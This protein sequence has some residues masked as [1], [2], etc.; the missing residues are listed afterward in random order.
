MPGCGPAENRKPDKNINRIWGK[1]KDP[2][3]EKLISLIS[4]ACNC[5][6]LLFFKTTC[7]T[8]LLTKWSMVRGSVST[9]IRWG[10]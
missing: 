2:G 6:Q 1:R 4:L 5:V 10:L 7:N 3:T 9:A 8:A